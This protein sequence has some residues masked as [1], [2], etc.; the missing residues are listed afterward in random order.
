MAASPAAAPAPPSPPLFA[1]APVG[2]ALISGVEIAAQ[3][4]DGRWLVMR[5]GRNWEEIGWIGRA[6]LI[7]AA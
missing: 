4:P 7:I 5:Q 3:L 6:V 2:V 1:P